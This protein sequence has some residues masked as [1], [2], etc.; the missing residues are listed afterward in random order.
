[1]QK[2][3]GKGTYLQAPLRTGKHARLGYRY[4]SSIFDVVPIRLMKTPEKTN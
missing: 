2:K 1:M 4:R 3:K